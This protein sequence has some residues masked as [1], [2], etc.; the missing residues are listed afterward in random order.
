MS[1][2][3]CRRRR[4]GSVPIGPKLLRVLAVADMVV[5]CPHDDHFF[6][7]LRIV[8]RQQ[9]QNVAAIVVERLDVIALVAAG[10]HPIRLNLIEHI[11]GRRMSAAA[12]GRRGLRTHRQPAL[13]RARRARPP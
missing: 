2:W 7:E 4:C 10:R 11:L 8:A 3:R 13:R 5:V 9:H 12:A 1:R 6:L